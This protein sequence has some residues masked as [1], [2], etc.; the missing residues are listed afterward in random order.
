MSWE[1]VLGV[2]LGGHPGGLLGGGVLGRCSKQHKQH[3]QA[4]QGKKQGGHLGNRKPVGWQKRDAPGSS[5]SAFHA[6]MPLCL[7]GGRSAMEGC[8]RAGAVIRSAYLKEG[9]AASPR[10]DWRLLG[11]TQGIGA[12]T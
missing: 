3:V 12:S 5:W 8:E 1:G 2:V 7:L 11:Q 9:R 4:C 6:T 10:L